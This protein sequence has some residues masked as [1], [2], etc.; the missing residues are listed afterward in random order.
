MNTI[1]C[2]EI[3]S[4]DLEEF[5]N[6]INGSYNN[7][8]LNDT[9]Y[10]ITQNILLEIYG[11][12]NIR[13]ETAENFLNALSLRFN[14]VAPVYEKKFSILAETLDIENENFITSIKNFAEDKSNTIITSQNDYTKE[15]ETPTGVKASTDFVDKYTNNARKNESDGRSEERGKISHNEADTNELLNKIE[16]LENW[17]NMLLEK[18]A[19]EFNNLFIQFL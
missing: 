5:K 10:T 14:N 9:M 3:I 11:N 2:K 15:A 17:R 19:K 6:Q 12:S 16:K 13:Y 4:E 7:L 8:T 18:Y 1:L